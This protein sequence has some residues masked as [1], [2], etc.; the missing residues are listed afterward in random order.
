[1]EY[2]MNRDELDVTIFVRR[3]SACILRRRVDLEY[4]SETE[5][6][7]WKYKRNRKYKEARLNRKYERMQDPGIL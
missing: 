1:M 7:I 5:I 6:D 2:R 3:L 4:W